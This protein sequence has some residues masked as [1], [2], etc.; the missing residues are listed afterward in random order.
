MPL[1]MEVGLD[2]GHIV[3][4]EDPASPLPRK[5]HSSRRLFGPCL[6]WPQSYISATAAL[7]FMYYIVVVIV[8]I[9]LRSLV[10]AARSSTEMNDADHYVLLPFSC[11]YCLLPLLIHHLHH[12]QLSHSFTPGLKPTSFTK[13]FHHRLS[14]GLTAGLT[15]RT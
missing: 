4:D 3:L 11:S 5:G 10:M 14:S 7:L 8:N 12:P 6:L 1:G 13:L 15:P 2:P 9:Y